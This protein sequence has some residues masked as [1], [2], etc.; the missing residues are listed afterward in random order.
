M[1]NIS[2]RKEKAKKTPKK[3]FE[4]LLIDH[5]SNNG[6]ADVI[7]T[8]GLTDFYKANSSKESVFH[9]AK[10]EGEK[11]EVIISPVASKAN[12]KLVV[13]KVENESF[14]II[15]VHAKQTLR[16]FM[17]YIT[18][19]ST[20]TIVMPLSEFMEKR[21]LT[22]E[23]RARAEIVSDLKLLQDTCLVFDLCNFKGECVDNIHFNILTA[24]GRI[25]DGIIRAEFNPSLYD[26]L[27]KGLER[28][29]SSVFLTSKSDVL[30]RINFGQSSLGYTL[31]ELIEEY[32]SHNKYDKN[33]EY[34]KN[35]NIVISIKNILNKCRELPTRDEIMEHVEQARKEG[36]KNIK[37]RLNER[38]VQPVENA[39]NKLMNNGLFPEWTYCHAKGE[40][41]TDNEW[42]LYD[43]DLIQED[44]NKKYYG[45]YEIW[46]TLYIKIVFPANYPREDHDSSKVRA[47]ILKEKRDRAKRASKKRSKKS[48]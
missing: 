46:E 26:K 22:H 6:F 43:E 18:K 5:S 21:G 48:Q 23:S 36:N 42:G 2:N 31:G 27:K 12:T 32:L 4:S 29:D 20:P 8:V 16:I 7:N 15:P 38:I 3:T 37:P 14:N 13:S 9:K 1:T 30:D 44:N 11:G 41:L 28:K 34:E 39:L 25:K 33:N 10:I 35:E 17:K 19:N 47:N 45:N 24:T 40:P